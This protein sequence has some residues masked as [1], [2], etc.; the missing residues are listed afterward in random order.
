MHK[1][2]DPLER[3]LVVALVLDRVDFHNLCLQMAG[4]SYSC[5]G[6]RYYAASKGLRTLAPR[7]VTCEVFRVASVIPCTFAVAAKSASTVDTGRLALMRPHSSATARSTGRIRSAKDR[8]R[9]ESHFSRARALAGSFGR[10]RSIPLR[11]SP[12]TNALR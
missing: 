4:E 2:F 12:S 8:L 9:V 10:A 1:P 5:R 3:S 7:S 6:R 11:I